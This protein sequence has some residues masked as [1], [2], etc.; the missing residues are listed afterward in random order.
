ME[1]KTIKNIQ[2]VG[3]YLFKTFSDT[4]AEK[5][6]ISLALSGGNT[7]KELFEYW[8]ANY[9]QSPVWHA[10]NYY[11]VDERCVAPNDAESNYGVANS[12]FFSKLSI[13][14]NNIFRMRGEIN[15]TEEAANYKSILHKNI[16]LVNGYPSFDIIILGIGED[17]HTASIFP[18]QEEL[19]TRNES[20]VASIN[21]YSKQERISLSGKTINA[22]KHVLFVALGESKRDIL[23]EIIL[24]T[25]TKKYPA[26]HV[27]PTHGILEL[28]T[29]IDL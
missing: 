14:Q 27:A 20:V 8:A 17:G 18:G 26:Q 1:I 5:E 25:N 7:P 6:T 29:N 9:A 13:S 2:L 12:M 28:I 4:L 22:G 16:E 19:F 3:D 15:A 11:W 24:P 10:I 23:N 21:P